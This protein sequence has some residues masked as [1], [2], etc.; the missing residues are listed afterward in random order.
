MIKNSKNKSKQGNQFKT[1]S[2][3]AGE[4]FILVKQLFFG[5][6]SPVFLS[7]LLAGQFS[8]FAAPPLAI[9]SSKTLLILCCLYYLLMVVLITSS[10]QACTYLNC[11]STFKR[12]AFRKSPLCP[13]W[14][15]SLYTHPTNLCTV[16][17]PLISVIYPWRIHVQSK[18]SPSDVLDE[19][20]K[21]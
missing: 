6:L 8:S 5:C 19:W 9:S 3:F 20:Q 15:C 18:A 21:K 1:Y 14:K 16:Y 13:A 2:Y 17:S 7:S 10:C 12:A 11:F 4:V